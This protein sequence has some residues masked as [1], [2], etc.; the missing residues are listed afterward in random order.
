MKFCY[1]CK[2]TCIAH[3]PPKIMKDIFV[4]LKLVKKKLTKKII[5]CASE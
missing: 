5:L 1:Y 2:C 4:N 3:I